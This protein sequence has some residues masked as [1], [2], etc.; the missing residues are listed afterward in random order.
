MLWLKQPLVKIE[1]E[2]VNMHS[3]YLHPNSVLN[4]NSFREL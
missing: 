1:E 2:S 3:L 4:S